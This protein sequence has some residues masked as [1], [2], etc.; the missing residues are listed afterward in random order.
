MVLSVTRCLETDTRVYTRYWSL[1]L[2]TGQ[3]VQREAAASQKNTA[4][5]IAGLIT[6][7]LHL[8]AQVT[9]SQVGRVREV[10]CA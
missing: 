10:V 2:C 3:R 7:S 8:Q 5:Y 1:E 9:L 6:Q 4:P